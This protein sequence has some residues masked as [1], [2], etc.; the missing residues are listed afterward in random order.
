MIAWH[1]NKQRYPGAKF[2]QASIKCLQERFHEIEFCFLS[3]KRQISAKHDQVPWTG[4]GVA[5]GKIVEKAFAHVRVDVAMRSLTC[6]E[7]GEMKNAKGGQH[8]LERS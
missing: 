8:Y 7:I 3:A 1:R 5:L 4:L 6:M 2:L